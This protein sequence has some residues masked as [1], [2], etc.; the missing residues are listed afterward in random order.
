MH[1]MHCSKSNNTLLIH[2]LKLLSSQ[3]KFWNLQQV[4]FNKILKPTI[5]VG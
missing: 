3:V 2:I 5:T 4:N 1:D